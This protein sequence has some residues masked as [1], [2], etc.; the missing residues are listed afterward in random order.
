MHRLTLFLF[1]VLITASVAH[2]NWY[3]D[4]SNYRHDLILTVTGG[5]LTHQLHN[6]YP[7]AQVTGGNFSYTQLWYADLTDAVLKGVSLN[8]ASLWFSHL[9][10]A[11]LAGSDLDQTDFTQATLDFVKSGG[12]TGTPAVLLPAGK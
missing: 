3:V 9:T 10:S 11:D 12:L 4:T 2:A 6:L 7:G 8:S 5:V 1:A